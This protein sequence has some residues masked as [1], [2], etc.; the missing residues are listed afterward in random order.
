VAKSIAKRRGAR[1]LA[2][3]SGGCESRRGSIAIHEE[4]EAEA[5]AGWTAQ[6]RVEVERRR[7]AQS[8]LAA[9]ATAVDAE[10]MLA[11]AQTL[12]A[13]YLA[14]WDFA[15]AA[16]TAARAALEGAP[17]EA[18]EG[19][20]TATKELV[21]A[22][23]LVCG[24]AGA[25]RGA[26]RVADLSAYVQ[27]LRKHAKAIQQSA[28]GLGRGRA[29]KRRPTIALLLKGVEA[30]IAKSDLPSAVE[31]LLAAV[32]DFLPELQ[33]RTNATSVAA[34]RAAVAEEAQDRGRRKSKRLDAEDVLVLV[35]HHAF[36][37]PDGKTE[38]H[39]LTSR[40]AWDLVKPGNR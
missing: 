33:V 17:P 16:V 7:A 11:A 5:L 8:A 32:P 38:R 10:T 27:E 25:A 13:E 20:F 30:A 18:R 34:A 29:S 39:K 4:T 28:A 35:L 21:G 22:L 19:L 15:A 1:S 23:D 14:R 26:G 37:V 6:H 36:T 31:Y 9:K 3:R 2:Q 40:E 12:P 24:P